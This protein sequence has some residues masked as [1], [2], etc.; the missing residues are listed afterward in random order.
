MNKR[1]ETISNIYKSTQGCYIKYIEIDAG[2]FAIDL[3]SPEISDMSTN[4]ILGQYSCICL[5]SLNIHID[6]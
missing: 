4:V 2:M 5:F 3:S 1:V 6:V